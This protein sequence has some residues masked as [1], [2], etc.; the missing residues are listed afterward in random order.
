MGNIVT[1]NQV[2][3]ITLK[4][5]GLSTLGGRK[6]WF[7][8]SVSRLNDESRGKFLGEFSPADR[9]LV[10]TRN[11]QFRT[12]GF[13]LSQHFEDNILLIEKFNPARVF[14]AIYWDPEQTF[15]YVKRFSFEETEKLQYFIH[16]SNDSKLVSLT[17][18]E[19]PRFEIRFGGKH[20][21]RDSEI[22]EVAG[23]IAVKGYKAKGKRLTNYTVENIMELEPVVRKETQPLPQETSEAD[24][25]VMDDDTGELQKKISSD[26]PAQMKL[27]L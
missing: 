13:D 12:T 17:E 4:E 10:V 23:F 19:Y 8:D 16:E 26:D 3:R 11:G 1:K 2:L 6:I 22:I 14:S 24:E 21:G 25:P 7:D 20:Q 5:K 15:Y 27:E 18:V 9:I